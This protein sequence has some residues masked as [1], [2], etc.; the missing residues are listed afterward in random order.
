MYIIYIYIYIY[1]YIYE[2]LKSLVN[3]ERKN[4]FGLHLVWNLESTSPWRLKCCFIILDLPCGFLQAWVSCPWFSY[5]VFGFGSGFCARDH[6]VLSRTWILGQIS[7]DSMLPET[8]SKRLQV[9]VFWLPVNWGDGD[10]EKSPSSITCL[11]SYLSAMDF[12]RI[13]K[14]NPGHA[15]SLLLS[16]SL[17]VSREFWELFG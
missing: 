13:N 17:I 3:V 14:V 7:A 1:S 5:R 11:Q 9:V 4:S 10:A 2:F 12:S 6:S 8:R 15:Q 16:S